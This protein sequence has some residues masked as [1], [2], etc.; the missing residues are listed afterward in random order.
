MDM[1]AVI[2][3]AAASGNGC[4]RMILLA[5]RPNGCRNEHAVQNQDIAK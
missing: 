1:T 5:P 2:A 3:G 4:G